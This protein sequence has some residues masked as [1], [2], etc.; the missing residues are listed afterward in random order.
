MYSTSLLGPLFD[1]TGPRG[2]I[3]LGVTASKTVAEALSSIRKRNHNTENL[4]LIHNMLQ[5][6]RNRT[7]EDA[8]DKPQWKAS[9]DVYKPFFN[10]KTTWLQLRQE[11]SVLD[12]YKGVWF[13]H[14]TPK[15]SFCAWLAINRLATGDRMLSGNS[16]VHSSC[17]LCQQSLETRNHLFF[18]VAAA[19]TRGICSGLVQRSMVLSFNAKI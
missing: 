13:S 14:S 17:V 5:T 11:G 1:I 9:G 15:Y 12:W 8:A 3:D 16:N 2:F 6:Y 19:Q 10:T 4:Q 18:N 7:P